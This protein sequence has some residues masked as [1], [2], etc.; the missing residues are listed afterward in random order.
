M[1]NYDPTVNLR[2][3]PM[4]M[5]RFGTNP[6]GEP[7]YRIVFAP[8]RYFL[9]FGEWPDGSKCAQWSPLYNELRNPNIWVMEKWQPAEQIAQCSRAAW[10][11]QYSCL[12]PWPERGDYEACHFF[13]NG[14]PD[15]ANLEKLVWLVSNKP[16]LHDTVMWHRQDAQREIKEKR[17]LAEEMIRSKLPA[18][19]GRVL[20]SSRIQRGSKTVKE[21]R[22]AQELGLPTT[23]GLRTIPNRSTSA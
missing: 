17:N 8:S 5:K 15:D 10:D 14:A 19:G 11:M 9:V 3:Y 7:L 22:S 23:P 4:P 16:T 6:Y 18:F 12:G 20:S 21:L 2:H 1:L 13:E